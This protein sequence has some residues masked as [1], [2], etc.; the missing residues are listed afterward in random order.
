VLKARLGFS[1]SFLDALA[2]R[3][4]DWITPNTITLSSLVF[5][6]LG[7][8][9][10][11]FYGSLS[12]ALVLFLVTGFADAF[13]GAVARARKRVTPFGAFLDGVV[14]RFNEALLLFG[15][16]AVTPPLP[17]FLIPAWA[18]LSLLLFFGT[19][20]TSFVRA[21]ADHRRVVTDERVLKQM[22]GLLE[23]GERLALLFTGL[24]AALVFSN[25]LLL[26]YAIAL[27]TLLA[28]VTVTQRILAVYFHAKQQAR[29]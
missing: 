27:A 2:T 21:Y 8:I 11:A 25:N 9:A 1:N 7:F 20:M 15:L 16:M 23:R 10:L 17:S 19:C 22:G 13:D 14:D 18:W 29:D 24:T 5:A 12:A 26:V 28:L 6:V 4:P 3:T